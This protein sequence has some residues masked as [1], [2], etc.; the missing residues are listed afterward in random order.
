MLGVFVYS[1]YAFATGFEGA[2]TI[3]LG[4]LRDAKGRFRGLGFRV[5]GWGFRVYGWGFL[6]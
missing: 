4:V 2:I 6:V 5:G 1:S 3:H